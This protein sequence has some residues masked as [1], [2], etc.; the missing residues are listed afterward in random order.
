VLEAD[1]EGITVVEEPRAPDMP[2]LSLDAIAYD[3][4]GAVTISGRG[5]PGRQVRLYLDNALIGDAAVDDDGQ[6]R[7]T[8]PGSVEPGIYT[9]RVDELGEDGQ[10]TA[11]VES[12]FKREAPEALAAAL[13]QGTPEAPEPEAEAPAE[14][15]ETGE[16]V[17]VAEA[18]V[19]EAVEPP[20]EGADAPPRPESD[21]DTTT[22]PAAATPP[23]PAPEESATDATPPIEPEVAETPGIEAPAQPEPSGDAGVEVAGETRAPEGQPEP[24]AGADALE[25]P[26]PEPMISA[27]TVQPGSTLWAISRERYGQGILYVEV[28][29]ANRDKIRDPDLIYPGQVFA[30]PELGTVKGR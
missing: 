2:A 21:P 15:P 25:S 28:F 9:L 16:S 17:E 19:P 18:E 5:E 3:E 6:W 1:S 30:L 13:G 8:L 23:T 22:E 24:P 14:A 26:A 27:I 11:R 29:E 10:V 4:T 7:L 20:E 12:P